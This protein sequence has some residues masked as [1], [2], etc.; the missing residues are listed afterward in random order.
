MKKLF[1]LATLAFAMTS[2][3]NEEPK[4]EDVSVEQGIQQMTEAV[5]DTNAVA[6]AATTDTAAT[7][8]K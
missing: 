2:C 5:A 8:T 7:P 1:F 4:T 3:K 6:P